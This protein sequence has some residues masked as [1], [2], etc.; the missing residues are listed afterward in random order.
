MKEG[1]PCKGGP[2][3]KETKTVQRQFSSHDSGTASTAS[4]KNASGE[5]GYPTARRLPAVKPAVLKPK[6][7]PASRE[8]GHNKAR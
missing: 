5:R 6:D 2:D 1:P 3:R 4:G 7:V 8:P